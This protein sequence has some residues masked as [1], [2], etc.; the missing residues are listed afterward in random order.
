MKIHIRF[1]KR[2]KKDFEGNLRLDCSIEGVRFRRYLKI[3]IKETSWNKNKERVKSNYSNA[4][5]INK[6]LDFIYNIINK[7]YYELVNNHIPISK[8]VLSDKFDE[9]MNGV[10]RRISFFDYVYEF[11][12]NSRNSKTKGTCDGYIYLINSLKEFEK[13]YRR[14]IDWNNFDYK[15]Y[16]DYQTFQYDIKGNSQTLFGKR[17]SQIKT[18]L[19]QAT[20]LGLNKHLIF[21]EY[22]VLKTKSK[23]EYLNEVEIKLLW[24]LDLSEK[25]RLEKVRDIFLVCCYT[26]VR[27]SEYKNLKRE[28]IELGENGKSINYYSK[29]TKKY[30][31]TICNDNALELLNK[32][33]FDLPHISGQKYN[34]YIKEVCELAR[35]DAVITVHT[36]K[37]GKPITYQKKKFELISSHTARRSFVTNLYKKNVPTNQIMVATGHTKEDTLS[38]YIQASAIESIDLIHQTL[39]KSG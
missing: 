33:K 39:K 5:E 32:Y 21:R 4:F 2:N 14:R 12:E 7:I 15:F 29:K 27:F 28:N 16:T 10:N 20:K 22:K 8:S 13:Q 23:K 18:I 37:S 24:N 31:H 6:R 34:K 9:K 35:I 19:N 11:V 1:L 30:V 17:I 36:Y 38:N 25:R 3:R 26:G